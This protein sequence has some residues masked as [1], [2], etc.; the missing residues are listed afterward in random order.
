MSDPVTRATFEATIARLDSADATNQLLLNA[1]IAE[2]RREF[3]DMKSELAK[4]NDK[5]DTVI[6]NQN[7]LKGRDGVVLFLIGAA[8]SICCTVIAASILG[9]IR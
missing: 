6:D 1:H 2:Y 5:L 7:R 9:V 3:G 8:V 4:A